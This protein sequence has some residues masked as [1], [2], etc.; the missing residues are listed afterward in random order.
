MW[1]LRRSRPI[2][3]EPNPIIDRVVEP[4]SASEVSL[5]CLHGNVSQ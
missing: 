3:F 5:G 4:L 2:R 1:N